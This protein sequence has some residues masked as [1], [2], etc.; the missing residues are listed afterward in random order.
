MRQ[1]TAAVI[2]EDGKLLLARRAPDEKL[3]GMWELPGG[4]T[5]AGETPQECLRRELIEELSMTAEVGAV[6][7]TTVYHYDHGAFEML[8]LE[9]VRT[10]DFSLSVH[11]EARWVSLAEADLLPLA[12]ADVELLRKIRQGDGLR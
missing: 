1:V 5:E 7:A 3:A 8:A 12:P 11:D 6:I 9:V 10:S 4:K 2:I